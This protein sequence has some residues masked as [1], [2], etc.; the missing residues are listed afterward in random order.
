MGPPLRTKTV[1]A[2]DD[3]YGKEPTG[4]LPCGHSGFTWCE[5]A[6]F[7]A[8]GFYSTIQT[9]R[10]VALFNAHGK[11]ISFG[12]EAA[13]DLAGLSLSLLW[14]DTALV[15]IEG[16]RKGVLTHSRALAASRNVVIRPELD[17]D[18]ID[19]VSLSAGGAHVMVEDISVI[20]GEV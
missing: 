4:P 20:L 5:N 16:S 19:R 14:V 18:G 17:F 1:I 15:L 12:R 13:F 6:W 3:L 9:G 7:L 2:F 8:K 10:R 11:T